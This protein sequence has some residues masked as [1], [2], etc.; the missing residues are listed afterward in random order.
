MDKMYAFWVLRGMESRITGNAGAAF[1]SINKGDI[2]EIG[3]PLPP[4]EVQKEVVAEIEAYRK[5]IDGAQATIVDHEQ[6]IQDTI[7]R[8]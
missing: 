7:D 3:I 1:A 2:E 6:K 5:I 8:V 4:M